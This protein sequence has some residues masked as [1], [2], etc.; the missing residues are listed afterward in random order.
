[1][2]KPPVEPGENL[3]PCSFPLINST[4]ARRRGRRIRLRTLVIPIQE[5]QH[6]GPQKFRLAQ[7]QV[8]RAEAIQQF[9][10]SLDD[11]GALFG[12]FHDRSLSDLFPAVPSSPAL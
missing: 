5:D 3:E 4:K 12:T 7:S 8:W 6:L 2:V 11:L 1:M 10:Q 9:S